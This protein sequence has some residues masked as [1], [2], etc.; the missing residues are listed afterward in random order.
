MSEFNTPA[1]NGPYINDVERAMHVRDQISQGVD[2]QEFANCKGANPDIFYSD[3]KRDVVDAKFICSRC[4]VRQECLNYALK[5]NDPKG[6]FGIWGE[7]TEYE[8]RA[9][10]ERNYFDT[11]L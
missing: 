8:R 4:V 9:I 7:K 11:S 1:N 6:V 3:N 2:W 5:Y 10:R